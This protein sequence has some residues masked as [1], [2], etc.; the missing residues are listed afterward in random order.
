VLRPSYREDIDG[1]RNREWCLFIPSVGMEIDIKVEF[2]FTAG[3]PGKTWGDPE[4][5]WPPEPDRIDIISVT[6][7]ESGVCCMDVLRR[8]VVPLRYPWPGRT[9]ETL[10]SKL[11]DEMAEAARD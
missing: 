11:T 10:L 5:C 7:L 3:D 9:H 8:E 4:N 2:E 1:V 6:G